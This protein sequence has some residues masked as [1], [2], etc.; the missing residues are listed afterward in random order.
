MNGEIGTYSFLPWLRQG[1]SNKIVTADLDAS[2][3]TRATINVNLNVKGSGGE[4]GNTTTTVSRDV[5]LYGPGDVIGI[6]SQSIIR[7]EPHDWIT[8]FEP[9]YLPYIEFYEED[10]PWRYTPAAPAGGRLRPWLTLIVLRE[11]EFTDGTNVL[12]KPLPFIE[13]SANPLES[14]F[15]KA[16]ELWAWAHV[17]VNKNIAG[18]DT[19]PHAPNIDDV[20]QQLSSLIDQNADLAYSRITCPRKL[21][22][23][24]RYHG[25]LIPTFET[26]RLAGLGMDPTTAP[27]A[28]F[29]A[30][31]EGRVA[32]TRFPFYHRWSFRTGTRG[33]FEFLVRL[34]EPQ[35]ADE[36][37]GRRDMDVQNPGSNIPG[38]TTPELEGIL[39]LGGALLAP[40]SDAAELELKKWED[41]DQPAPHPFQT[42]LAGFIN[43]A[44]DYATK[45]PADANQ[46]AAI[47]PA[48]SNDPDP[49]ITPPVY[50]RWHALTNRLL[51]QA[52]GSDAPNKTNWVHDLNLDP[53]WRSAAGFGTDV[54]IDNQEFYMDAAWD[55]VGDVLEANRK[56]RLAQLAKQSST[57]WFD[58]HM[59]PMHA[60]S[61]EKFVSMTA[62]MQKR[63]MNGGT[64]AYHQISQSAV[65]P[66]M[67]SAPLRRMLRPNARL[68]RYAN[69]DDTI[70]RDN[71]I[72]RANAQIV[73]AAPPNTVPE[74]LL[75][76][77]EIADEM[78]P[79]GVSGWFL[80]FLV[81]YPWL[82]FVLW[83]TAAGLI[84]LA[85]LLGAG[86]GVWALAVGAAAGLMVLA[87]RISS[88]TTQTA[89]ADSI[90]GENISP[91]S[92]DRLP[93]SSTFELTPSTTPA[94]SASLPPS[95]ST[96]TGGVDSI[97]ATRFK[98]ALK[99]A[100]HAMQAGIQAG[101][102]L[103]PV[104]I[105]VDATATASLE[106]IDPRITIP[107]YVLG[108]IKFPSHII[109]LIGEKFIEAMAYPEFDTP[110][111]KPLVDKSTELFVPNLNF[112][113]NNS[114]TLLN[115]NQRFIEAYMV[116]LN[117]EFARE[118][119][120]REYPTDQRGS[121]F[122]QFW[123]V[124]SFLSDTEDE[125]QRREEL[126][127]IPPL[128]RWSKFSSLGDHDHR[129]EGLDNEEEL[130]LV[131]R[132]E[133]LKKYPNAVIYAHKAM[134]QPKSDTDPTPDK[135]KERIFDPSAELKFPI[136]EAKVKPDIYFF[137]F[138]LTEDVARG[139]SSVDDDPGWFFV[140][141]ER[142]GE[143][144]FGLDIE[145]DGDLQVW[146]DLSWPDIAPS[147]S[148]GDFIDIAAAPTPVLS[149]TVPT[150]DDQEKAEQWEEDRLLSWTD[151]LTSAELA[152]IMFQ[153]PVLIGVHASEMLPES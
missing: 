148:D 9:N 132:G 41:W 43:L 49:L 100:Y 141:K 91:E 108:T 142:P 147:L 101:I 109:K 80:D 35:K 38:I 19:S 146:N 119:L 122:R 22:P 99:D 30:W 145:R 1:I 15:P 20:L 153:S 81:K 93:A 68:D 106:A 17:H 94:A 61:A 33:D 135:L 47:D 84:L 129:E 88:L 34:L 65:T 74:S 50:G 29:S 117:H 7:T 72:A 137:G 71:L 6:E 133:L 103:A 134:W 64:T 46:D 83:A 102:K 152:Y 96:D 115:T 77:E 66:A 56:I 10:F 57:Y 48:I 23:S 113:E 104:A 52:D 98:T 76:L 140:I 105:N 16:D 45:I 149:T 25:F 69:F 13:V 8:N 14:V 59:K 53:R 39:K 78:R 97:Q 107:R 130:V 116:G 58:T 143:P 73:T 75:T 27:H 37:V 42:H 4:A 125:E 85:L 5:A 95:E 2:V 110:M 31:G 44:D 79:K 124:S 87:R 123:D 151:N 112:I 114:I 121:Y 111:Y 3:I 63:V 136:Y 144:R 138:D 150:G 82:K 70:N 36:R 86:A 60:R 92:V 127:D 55:Q 11:D 90:R 24:A 139:D 118:L 54:V 32:P 40:L 126:K 18:T 120:W 128:H 67:T 26:G 21:E 28:T 12:D 89:D 51:K 62:P 131:I